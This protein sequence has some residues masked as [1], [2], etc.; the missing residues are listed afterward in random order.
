MLQNI[1]RSDHNNNI[2]R[3]ERDIKNKIERDKECSF[4][5][6]ADPAYNKYEKRVKTQIK[7]EEKK[8][9]NRV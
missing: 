1:N 7:R 9:I 6:I 2:N 4:D 5:K 8:S 3:Y